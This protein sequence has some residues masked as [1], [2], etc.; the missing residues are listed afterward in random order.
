MKYILGLCLFS[1]LFAQATF[2]NQAS[3]SFESVVSFSCT[4]QPNGI[5]WFTGNTTNNSLKGSIFSEEFPWTFDNQ[6]LREN[7]MPEED[8]AVGVI[9]DFLGSGE[10]IFGG[11][12][13]P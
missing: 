5:A 9:R 4:S 10:D 6:I 3:E 8:L 2:A 12:A 7:E 13:Q 1:S 11:F